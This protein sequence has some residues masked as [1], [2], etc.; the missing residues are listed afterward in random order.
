[1]LLGALLVEG[2]VVSLKEH[3]QHF[4]NFVEKTEF[5]EKL[6]SLLDQ[7]NRSLDIIDVC[8]E[9]I[10]VLL[11]YGIPEVN[12]ARMRVNLVPALEN[13]EIEAM[14]VSNK[15]EINCSISFAER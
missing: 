11:D 8:M 4:I 9:I 1:M 6:A 13:L 7:F 2:S 12:A 3:T 10:G 5:M 14:E 15:R